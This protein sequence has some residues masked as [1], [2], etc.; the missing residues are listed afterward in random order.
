MVRRS[1]SFFII[2]LAAVACSASPEPT[3]ETRQAI[4]RGIDSEPAQDYVVLLYAKDDDTACTGTLIAPNLVL[5]ARH[6]V[7]RVQLQSF[8][9]DE[10]GNISGISGP[11]I[12][13]DHAPGSLLVYTGSV[14]ANAPTMNPDAIGTKIFHDAAKNLC[15]HDLSLILL[16]REISNAPFAHI[17]LDDTVTLG[18]TFTAVGWGV[19]DKEFVPF[20]RKQ[21][22][23]VKITAVGPAAAGMTFQ[24][25]PPNDFQVGESI[26]AGDSGGPALDTTSNAILG[27]TSRGGNGQPSNPNNPAAECLFATNFYTQTS[28]YKDLILSAFAESGHDPWVEGGPDPR[29]LKFGEA[30]AN[31]DECRSAICATYKA[32]PPYCS[33]DCAAD[34]ASC[35]MGYDCKDPGD[36]S[37]ICLPHEAPKKTDP[38]VTA[39]CAASGSAPSGSALLF[40]FVSLAVLRRR[41]SRAR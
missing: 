35:P 32:T 27:V 18:E 4:I 41:R 31:G 14:H 17:R 6:C 24:P 7:S 12:L 36:G 16:D 15:G 1:L 2:G 29:K 11:Q 26:C 30:C 9:C 25:T 34:P 22:K 13:S 39:G 28:A 40:A 37:L 8:G 10:M 21:R 38:T 20:Y 33:Q 23:N 5:T 19:T 3:A